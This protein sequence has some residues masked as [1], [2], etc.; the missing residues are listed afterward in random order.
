MVDAI[1]GN[2][3]QDKGQQSRLPHTEQHNLSD[4]SSNLPADLD[5]DR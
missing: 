1:D 2:K 3:G 4:E 5:Q